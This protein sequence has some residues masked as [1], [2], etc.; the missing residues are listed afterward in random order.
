MIQEKEISKILVPDRA[1]FNGKLRYFKAVGPICI[2]KKYMVILEDEKI[3]QVI[4][5]TRH[6]NCHPVTKIFCLPKH[7]IGKEFNRKIRKEIEYT[8][9]NYNLDDCYFKNWSDFKL[10]EAKEK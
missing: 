10:K 3:K 9:M 8:L 1:I 4:L 6:P 7:L 2:I 5:K